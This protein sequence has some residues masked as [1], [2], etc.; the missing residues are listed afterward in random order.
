MCQVVTLVY[1]EADEKVVERCMRYSGEENGKTSFDEWEEGG[2]NHTFR[3]GEGSGA[4]KPIMVNSMASGNDTSTTEP[5]TSTN[6]TTATSA[7]GAEEGHEN[8]L[9]DEFMAKG[10]LGARDDTSP[11]SRTTNISLVFVPSYPNIRST[12]AVAAGNDA[13]SAQQADDNEKL[14]MPLFR[15]NPSL[16]L[17]WPRRRLRMLP[18]IPPLPTRLH[19]SSSLSSSEVASTCMA[20]DRKVEVHQAADS[21]TPTTAFAPSSEASLL[22][23]L[24]MHRWAIRA[25]RV[26]IRQ[27]HEDGWSDYQRY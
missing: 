27:R 5:V 1:D 13:S 11:P 25:E 18:Q 16:Q 3:Y 6:R 15:V 4:V 10:P 14:N 22:A 24:R 17:R 2:A 8:L 7:I 9:N 26:L 19:L 12:K 23:L 21:A 20:D